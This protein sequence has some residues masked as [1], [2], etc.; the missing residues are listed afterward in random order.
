LVA[1]SATMREQMQQRLVRCLR[2]DL[3]APVD[4]SEH[5]VACLFDVPEHTI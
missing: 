5:A 1:L 3:C 4:A 2:P